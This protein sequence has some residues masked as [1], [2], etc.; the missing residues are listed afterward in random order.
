[1]PFMDLPDHLEQE[2]IDLTEII[3][4]LTETYLE[5]YTDE[6]KI[7]VLTNVIEAYLISLLPK[8]SDECADN[9]IEEY[10]LCC[11][12]RCKRMHKKL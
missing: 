6:T 1:M 4:D 2:I 5:K 10:F 3:Y 7:N 11:K 9:V 8:N 12:E